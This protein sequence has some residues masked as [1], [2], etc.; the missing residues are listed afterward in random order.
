M[1]PGD[2]ENGPPLRAP[3][4]EG[5][6][7]PMAASMLL[8][9]A[10]LAWASALGF[11]LCARL[12]LRGSNEAGG[13]RLSL[14]VFWMGAAGVAA[15]QGTRSVSV[16]L[17]HDSFVLIRALDQTATPAYCLSAAGLLYHVL[18]LLTGRRR[19]AIP[20]FAYYM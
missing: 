15:I 3:P 16:V 20:V 11:L 5:R 6:W 18:Y 19:L 7:G 2:S 14:A 12:A 10:I 4:G 8:A 13:A 9:S 17:G 1:P